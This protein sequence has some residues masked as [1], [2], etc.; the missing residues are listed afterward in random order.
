LLDFIKSKFKMNL[1][2]VGS[3]VSKFNQGIESLARTDDMLAVIGIIMLVGV[4][5]S[6]YGAFW[7]GRLA[8]AQYK[9][10]CTSS[11]PPLSQ[12]DEHKKTVRYTVLMAV[13]SALL[14]GLIVYIF[15]KQFTDKLAPVTE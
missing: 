4:I 3:S 7:Q 10:E 9:K 2:N 15:R 11:S 6:S 1:K 8:S 5:V 14:I 12:T 13:V